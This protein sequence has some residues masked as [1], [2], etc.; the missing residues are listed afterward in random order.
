MPIGSKRLCRPVV[1]RFLALGPVNYYVDHTSRFRRQTG[2]QRCVRSIAGALIGAGIPVRPVVWDR[3]LAD[4][5]PASSEALHHLARWSGPSASQWSVSQ[6]AQPHSTDQWLLIVELVSGPHQPL[7]HQ[8]R[9]AADRRGW[10]VAWIFHDAIP[11]RWA[12][13]YGA[14]AAHTAAH[15]AAY[16]VGLAD[17]ELVLA[18]SH[19]SAAQLRQFWRQRL[20][21]PRYP[22]QALPLPMELPAVP[23]LEAPMPLPAGQPLPL[24]CVASLEPRKNHRALLKAVAALAAQGRFTAELVL[25]GW[26]NDPQVV[27]MVQRALGLG[28]PLRWEADAEDL[29]LAELYRWCHLTVYPSLEEG[30]GLPVAESLWLRRPCLCSGEGALGELAQAGGCLPVDSGDWRALAAGLERLLHE[31]ALRLRLQNELQSRV[32]RTWAHYAQE[33]LHCLD[34]ASSSHCRQRVTA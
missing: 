34:Q 21:T 31:P 14:G 11:L 32:L 15:H 16:M 9:A 7:P 33:L 2:I 30:F 3:A 26:A 18:N 5:A 13:L 23:R 24:L 22:V 25:V 19:T 8:L 28:L 29:R 10:R 12:H 27:A 17:F 20:C 1:E 4:F 6:P